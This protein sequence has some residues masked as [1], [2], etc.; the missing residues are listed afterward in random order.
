MHRRDFVRLVGMSTATFLAGTMPAM[1]GPFESAD[2]EKLIPP[3]KKLH[4]DWVKAL[5]E[6]GTRDVYR[7]DD[8]KYIG[9]PIGGLCTG[10][11]YLGGDGKLWYWDI[12]NQYY[13]TGYA[14]PTYAAPYIPSSPLEQG[15]TLKTTASGNAKEWTLDKAGFPDVAFCGE[16]P[17]GFVEYT[18]KACPV[19]V[20]LEAFSPFTPLSIADSGF[21]ATAMR[22]TIHNTSAAPV[23]VE[24]TGHLE[25][26]A[27]VHSKYRYGA[28]GVWQN[29]IMR[30]GSALALELGFAPQAV[31]A[32]VTPPRPVIVFADFEG[33]DYRAWTQE[34]DA[35]GK[36]PTVETANPPRV[37]KFQGKSFANTYLNP[38]GD[39]LMGKLT[40]PEFTIE[41]TFIQFPHRRRQQ[42]VFDLHQFAGRWKRRAQLDLEPRYRRDAAAGLGCQRA[43]GK[44]GSHPNRR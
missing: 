4:P 18:D 17:F 1:A 23:D 37:T 24:L 35:F 43:S 39:T 31:T 2:F 13:F 10:Q 19:A 12:F 16:Y 29:R 11:L 41:R 32:P 15:F 40:S 20:S 25:N 21:P 9:M 44:K 22:Y 30:D 3:D 28:K 36:G 27:A 6:R 38:G 34:G 14:A 33:P 42:A 7:G 8:L 26:G 5:Y